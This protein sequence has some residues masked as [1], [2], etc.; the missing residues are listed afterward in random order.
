M[1]C[2]TCPALQQWS[3]GE[4]S[5]LDLAFSSTLYKH[6]CSAMKNGDLTLLNCEFCMSSLHTDVLIQ[7]TFSSPESVI[8]LLGLLIALQ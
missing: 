5:I 6:I 4:L 8:C 1:F 7:S 3:K 2:G